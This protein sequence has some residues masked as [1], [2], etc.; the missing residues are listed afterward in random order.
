MDS[1]P[2]WSIWR[3]LRC[4]VPA[5]AHRYGCAQAQPRPRPRRALAAPPPAVL[6][7]V[8]A[9][10]DHCG[11]CGT[12]VGRCFKRATS[13][14]AAVCFGLRLKPAA[15]RLPAVQRHYRLTEHQSSEVDDGGLPGHAAAA[16]A[17]GG[18][19][20]ARTGLVG[21]T[22]RPPPPP[23]VQQRG[24][25]MTNPVPWG[26]LP[27]DPAKNRAAVFTPYNIVSASGMCVLAC[28]HGSCLAVTARQAYPHSRGPGL[29]LKQAAGDQTVATVFFGLLAHRCLA[30]AS[31]T[32]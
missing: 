21:L 29:L 7:V 3:S 30:A 32:C 15:P 4:S 8:P 12:H 24:C 10:R 26:T 13:P 20:A 22:A 23:E 27:H 6:A 25:P 5:T 17:S 1:S 14:P 16:A 31:A 28:R 11:D 2:L 19:A 18:E 9:L